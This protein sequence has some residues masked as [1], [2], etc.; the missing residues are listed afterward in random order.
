MYTCVVRVHNCRY[1]CLCVCVFER[2]GILQSSRQWQTT[3][4]RPG[5]TQ[6]TW[7]CCPRW[8]QCRVAAAKLLLTTCWIQACTEVLQIAISF[9]A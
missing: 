8:L 6:N 4:P 7:R 2:V 1:I 3:M 5:Q 9:E